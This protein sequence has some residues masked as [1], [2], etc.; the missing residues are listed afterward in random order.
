MLDGLADGVISAYEKCLSVFD[1]KTLRCANGADTGDTCL[2]DAQIEAD[3]IVHRPFAYPFALAN[4]VK[5]FPGWTYGSEEQ[6]G[7]MIDAV[8]GAEP[9]HFPILNEKVQSI[10]RGNS[11]G[12]VRYMLARDAKFNPLQFSTQELAVRVREISDLF[13][14]TNPDLSAFL[15]RGGKL[16]LKGNGADYQRSVLQEITYYKSVVAKMGS[17]RADQFIRFY[18]TPGVNHPGNGVMSSGA[19]VPAKVDLLGALDGWVDSG[20]APGALMQVRQEAKAPFGIE[21]SRP[22]CLY[23]AYPRYKGEGDP[24]E[25]AS[26]ACMK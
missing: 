9:A 22:M 20:K 19:A 7:G 2:S 10:A 16:I 25:V 11:N 13:D 5:A 26:F 8:T 12:F 23:P 21:A 3:K 6:P 4:G 24:N 15:A 17:A 1:A 18:V 14:T